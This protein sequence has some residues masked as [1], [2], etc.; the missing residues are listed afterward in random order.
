MH[1]QYGPIIRVAPDEIA[2][3]H[4][5][6]WTD[7]LQTKPGSG[8]SGLAFP[9]DP[10]WWAPLPGVPPGLV[11][12]VDHETHALI[13][14][15]LNPGFT[16]RAMSLQEGT[17]HTYVDLLVSRWRDAISS[18]S[19]SSS[20]SSPSGND[21]GNGNGNGHD[22]S[23]R[24]GE[25]DIVR[26]FNYLTFDIV[27]TLAFAESFDCLESGQ[28]HGW[29]SLIF[30]TLKYNGVM[31]AARFYPALFTLL[32]K[33]VPDPMVQAQKDHDALIEDKVKRRLGLNDGRLD[34]MS[35]IQTAGI[36][37]LSDD[38]DADEKEKEKGTGK[39]VMS[40]GMVHSIFAQLSIAG[41]ETTAMALSGTVNLLVHNPEKMEILVK[42]VRARFKTYEE[43]TIPAV[44]ELVY[45]DAV[46]R[47]GLRLCPPVPYMP[48]RKVPEGGAVVCG[49]RL[50][51]G[52]SF[53]FF[54][55]SLLPPFTS[56]SPSPSFF[57]PSFLL[58]L[59]LSLL[60][61]NPLLCLSFCIFFFL[62]SFAL[63][64]KT[65]VSITF[66]AM[67]REPTSFHAATEFHP[68][69]WLSK[70]TEN[71][72]SPFYHDKRHAWQPFTLGPHVCIGQNLAWA[73]MRLTLAKVL[74]SF[75]LE[76]PADKSKHVLWESLRVFLL[77]EKKPIAVVVK[78]RSSSD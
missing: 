8:S 11:T 13:R 9:K 67:H 60:P 28:Y 3:A 77:I 45:L 40:M 38:D 31:I 17:V 1:R 65:R 41:S 33:L 58:S 61:S 63:T 21:H 59:F 27:G 66:N 20:S 49:R 26:W 72:E 51:G 71:S 36:K 52:V 42:E 25:V 16:S 46:L 68:E 23:Q 73:E 57:F 76:A 50:P 30:N 5:D 70:S 15:Q 18:S 54:S 2:Y 10:T 37:N 44:K 78:P 14:R 24:G 43:I 64:R 47:E 32:G 6:A 19:S 75:D 35:T 29:I 34:F 39:K 48:P 55:L 22:Q 12:F 62:F 7:I 56:S 53:F 4:P 69:R 74:W